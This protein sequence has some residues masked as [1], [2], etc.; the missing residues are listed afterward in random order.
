[1]SLRIACV[2]MRYCPDRS[3]MIHACRSMPILVTVTQQP[4]KFLREFSIQRCF[5]RWEYRVTAR[6]R[7]MNSTT[8]KVTTMMIL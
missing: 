8:M 4:R 7:T 5:F 2:P 1:M 3:A 6:A